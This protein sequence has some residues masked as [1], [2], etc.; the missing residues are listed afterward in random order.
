MALKEIN[1]AV[2]SDIVTK[3]FKLLDYSDNTQFEFIECEKVYIKKEGNKAVVGGKEKTDISRALM[4][5]V[6]EC[7]LGKTEFEISQKRHFDKL[8]FLIDLSRNGVI[9]V[10]KLK[11][12]IDYIALLGFNTLHLYMEDVF[13]LPGYP[14]FGYRRGKYSHE[15]LR[16][17]DDYAYGMGIEVIPSIQ[18]LGHMEQYVR[19]QEARDFTEN[20]RVLLC[21]EEKTY[22]FIETLIKTL[23]SCFR[24]KT[25]NINCDEA[26]GVGVKMMMR[27][28]KYTAPYN[29]VIN[30]LKRV[31]KICEKYGFDAIAN[32]D[33]FYGHLGN[34]YYDFSFNPDSEALSDLPM[35]NIQ[36]WDYYHTAYKDYETL[37]KGHLKL[38]RNVIFMGGIWIWSGQ[39]PNTKFTFETMNPALECM[40]D[41][42]IKNVTAATFGDD[43]TETNIAFALPQLLVFSEHCF[44][45]KDYSDEAVYNLSKN[46]LNLDMKA[47]IALADYH[48]PW[49]ENLPVEDYI[50]PNYM[51]KKL[52]YTD[53]LYNMTGTYDF[54]KIMPKHQKALETVKNTGKGTCWEKYFK[55]SRLVFEINVKKMEIMGRIREAYSNKDAG[56]LKKVSDIEIPY[57]VSHYEQLMLLHEEQWLNIYKP[58]GWEELNNRYSSTIGRLKYAKRTIDKLISGVIDEI[59]ELMYEFIEEAAPYQ[60]YKG[61]CKYKDV[62]TSGLPLL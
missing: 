12:I 29:I 55:Y 52:F 48:Y 44:L 30:H 61:V 50:F 16:A 58:F 53:I 17:I 39:L 14:H 26:Q 9:K 38:G 43:G 51:G 46:L 19:Y 41:Y 47:L 7:R 5:Y 31:M 20:T 40:I 4:L 62:R 45:G 27:Q 32:G 25:I 60:P 10:S 18:T 35:F 21:G 33:L 2:V 34:G 8:G 54:S 42:G 15:E 28:K 49:I 23:R 57:L 59:P 37:L 6:T 1:N 13:D 22:V 3:V 56:W 11:E 24:T 36:Y